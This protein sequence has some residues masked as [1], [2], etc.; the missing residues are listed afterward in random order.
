M[1]DNCNI[2][3]MAPA[4]LITNVYGSGDFYEMAYDDHTH[5]RTV[6]LPAAMSYRPA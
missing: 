2:I 1:P 3:A 5:K 6:R 4:S